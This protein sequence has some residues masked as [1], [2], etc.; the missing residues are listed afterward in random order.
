MTNRKL[1]LV[2]LGLSFLLLSCLTMSS[3]YV[4]YLITGMPP[5][6]AIPITVMLFSISVII[7]G[8]I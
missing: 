6:L 5:L 3:I 7:G 4:I 8:L 2:C 1:A